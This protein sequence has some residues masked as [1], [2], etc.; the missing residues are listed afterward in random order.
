MDLLEQVQRWA[1]KMI[2]IIWLEH[3]S[4]KEQ[5]RKLRLFSL[6]NRRLLGDFIA[7]FQY[8]ME[9]YMKETERHFTRSCRDRKR[10]NSG[11]LK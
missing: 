8:I 11:K 6:K 2:W 4:Y 1:T 10:G 9:S 3:L 7:A 5:V